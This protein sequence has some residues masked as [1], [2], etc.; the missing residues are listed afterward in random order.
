MQIK[1]RP[2]K[3]HHQDRHFQE[4]KE[5]I[6]Q[7]AANTP[8][9]VMMITS[10]P[11]E[12]KASGTPR[13]TRRRRPDHHHSHSPPHHPRHPAVHAHPRPPHC[14]PAPPHRVP[15]STD[16]RPVL[17]TNQTRTYAHTLPTPTCA[18]TRTSHHL[19]ATVT[20]HMAPRHAV[21][22]HDRDDRR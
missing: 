4:L 7:S 22:D 21:A 13:P 5:L 1:F 19:S 8:G 6:S 2:G 11:A 15:T 9:P 12:I 3:Q 16:H 10:V 20:P 17:N 18:R 14:C